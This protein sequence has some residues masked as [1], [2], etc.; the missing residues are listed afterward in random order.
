MPSVFSCED[1]V[2][3]AD[4]SENVVIK[5]TATTSSNALFNSTSFAGTVGG[6]LNQSASSLSTGCPVYPSSGTSRG[7]TTEGQ[8]VSMISAGHPV[9]NSSTVIAVTTDG[10]LNQSAQLVSTGHPVYPFNSTSRRDTGGQTVP[11]MSTG[12][13]A[14]DTGGRLHQ[15]APLMSTGRGLMATSIAPSHSVVSLL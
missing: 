4:S 7:D 5:S 10:R 13:P 2:G 9:S 3:H 8:S 1:N 15:S 11:V 14:V 12:H 6:H